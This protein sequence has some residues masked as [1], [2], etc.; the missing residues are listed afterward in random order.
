[1]SLSS[2]DDS[3]VETDTDEEETD[4][5]QELGKETFDEL[6][7]WLA[8]ACVNYVALHR[9]RAS[10][11]TTNSAMLTRSWRD[12][13]QKV[14]EAFPDLPEQFTDPEECD[15]YDEGLADMFERCVFQGWMAVGRDDLRQRVKH[16]PTE[17]ALAIA[18][19]HHAIATADANMTSFVCE[20][21][22]NPPMAPQRLLSVVSRAVAERRP[23]SPSYTTMGFNFA[24]ADDLLRHALGGR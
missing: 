15:E 2:S 9:N 1:M 11:G 14:R 13:S 24:A 4:W 18:K 21:L 5:E 10:H 7:E 19:A 20:L 3:L 23:S 12:L 6:A 17:D 22:E 8:N 16:L